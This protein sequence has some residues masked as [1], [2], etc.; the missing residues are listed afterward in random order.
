MKVLI[1]ACVLYPTVMRE[2]VLGAAKLGLF[3]PLWSPRI[4]EEWARAAAR[5]GPDQETFARGE[6]ALLNANWPKASIRPHDGVEARLWLPDQNDIHVLAAAISG[7]ADVLLTLNNADFP[8]HTL[9][10]EGLRRESPDLFLRGF[11]D[12]HPA[13]MVMLADRVLDE[14]IRLSGDDSWTLRKLMK[15]ARLPRLG[16]ALENQA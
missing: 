1:D 2:M 6:I 9:A 7:G 5:F 12:S 8:R 4:L 11:V 3:T 16:K 13:D 15:K 14:A 10:E